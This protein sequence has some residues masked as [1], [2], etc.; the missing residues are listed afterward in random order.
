MVLIKKLMDLMNSYQF[1]I[2]ASVLNHEAED[3][4]DS[5]LKAGCDDATIAFQKGVIILE[6]DRE[7]RSYAGALVSAIRDV[8]SAGAHV[9]RIEP[10]YLVN[11]SDIASRSNYSR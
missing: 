8:R 7:A 9:E 4:G 1:T 11:L 6:F 5:F 10:D 2:I 3:F